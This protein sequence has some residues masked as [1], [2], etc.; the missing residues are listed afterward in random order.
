[1]KTV[2]TF[3]WSGV[4]L[5]EAKAQLAELEYASERGAQAAVMQAEIEADLQHLNMLTPI[6]EL[7]Q[8][9]KKFNDEASCVYAAETLH[10]L[11]YV[12]DPSN[13]RAVAEGLG[14]ALSNLW[15]KIKAMFK[16]IWDFFFGS[17]NSL[18]K[19]ANSIKVTCNS[20]ST[21]F[22]DVLEGFNK[23]DDT[24]KTAIL[25]NNNIELFD[26]TPD[27]ANKFYDYAKKSFFDLQKIVGEF[28]QN[29]SSAAN[30]NNDLNGT[31]GP[32][33]LIDA[34]KKVNTDAEEIKKVSV[35]KLSV[36]TVEDFKKVYANKESYKKIIDGMESLGIGLINLKAA[37][38]KI[39]AISNLGQNYVSAV[40]GLGTT[41]ASSSELVTK[42]AMK[43]VRIFSVRLIVAAVTAT[44]PAPA[45]QAPAAQAPATPATPKKTVK[46]NDGR[47]VDISDLNRL[48]V[49]E[50]VQIEVSDAFDNLP[51]ND[52]TQISTSL[53]QKRAEATRNAQ[54]PD[55]TIGE[56]EDTDE[57]NHLNA[58]QHRYQPSF[59]LSK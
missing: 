46:L 23:L 7:V 44:P 45:A 27:A 8:Q 50:L 10:A 14:E 47:V 4:K 58:I 17:N 19:D 16:K 11:G 54:G 28:L 33:N 43:I 51:L 25:A 15:E 59:K 49:Q 55:S 29:A 22:N 5:A 39:L 12:D 37:S 21:Q 35:S 48:S 20:M 24:T 30:S 42:T 13:V 6:L 9:N 52:Q 56:L 53:N 31:A 26:I 18:G 36:K 41:L 34:L 2:E 32:Q 40:S 57:P 1:M 3:K 38:D